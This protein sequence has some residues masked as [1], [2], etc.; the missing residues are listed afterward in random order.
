MC[1]LRSVSKFQPIVKENARMD[2]TGMHIGSCIQKEFLTANKNESH[3]IEFGWPLIS[4]LPHDVA[5]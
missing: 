4:G 1:K 2:G 3:S 5:K